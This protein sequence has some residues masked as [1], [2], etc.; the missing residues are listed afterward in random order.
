MLTGICN[1]Q[2]CFL[3]ISYRD[4]RQKMAEPKEVVSTESS[5]PRIAN[6]KDKSKYQAFKS[7]D[8]DSSDVDEVD[9]Y[10][11]FVIEN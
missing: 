11:R 9:G 2:N 4:N 8:E 3:N 6:K 10:L 7:D 5:S 1:E